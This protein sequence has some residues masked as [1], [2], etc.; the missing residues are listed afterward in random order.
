MTLAAGSVVAGRYTLEQTL[1]RGATATVWLARDSTTGDDVAVKVLHAE[2]AGSSVRV[3]FEREARR[4]AGLLHPHILPALDAGEVEDTLYFTQPLMPDGTL[5]QRLTRERQLS[6]EE[7]LRIGR[8]IAEALAYAHERTFVHRDVKPEN[9]LFGDGEV[10]LADFGIARSI[11]RSLGESSTSRLVV[12]GT[13]AYM[14]PEQASGVA[15]CD[16]RSDIFSLG[17]VL[18]ECLAGVP[19][20]VGASPDAIIA[21]VITTEPR[22]L[23][24][25]RDAVPDALA[26]IIVRCMAKR[27]ADRFRDARSLAEALAKPDRRQPPRPLVPSPLVST[28]VVPP[29]AHWGRIASGAGLIFGGVAFTAWLARSPSPPTPLLVAP[30]TARLV[31]F[32]LERPDGSRDDARFDDDLL[33]DG[34]RRGVGGPTLE[35]QVQVADALSRTPDSVVDRPAVVARALGAG[36]YVRGLLRPRGEEMLASI[37][38]YDVDSAKALVEKEV[39]VP[40]L[41]ALAAEAYART[42]AELLVRGRPG[43]VSGTPLRAGYSVPAMQAFVAGRQALDDWDLTRAESEFERA[44]GFD[45]TDVQAMLLLAQVRAWLGRPSSSWRE[46]AARA[47]ASATVLPDRERLLARGLSA[48]AEDRYADACDAYRT[49]RD[50]NPQDFAA[51]YGLGQCLSMDEVVV[52]DRAASPSGWRFR[53]SRQGAQLAYFTAFRLLPTVHRGFRRDGFDTNWSMFFLLPTNIRQ[54]ISADSQ[55]RFLARPTL[56]GDTLAMIPYLQEVVFRG[57]NAAVPAGFAK[58]IAQQRREFRATAMGWSSAFP[59]SS[60]AKEAVSLALELLEDPAALDTIRVARALATDRTRRWDLAAAEVSLLVRF[61]LPDDLPALR[62]AGAL[63]DS[64]LRTVPSGPAIS[65]ESLELL[66]ILRGRCDDAMRFAARRTV[67]S[68]E[69]EPPSAAMAESRALLDRVAMRCDAVGDTRVIG[70]FVGR[71]DRD[72]LY[73]DAPDRAY[74]DQVMLYRQV[75]MAS[76][77]DSAL[78][79]RLALTVPLPLM[80]AA[81]AVARHDPSAARAALGEFDLAATDAIPMTPDFALIAARLWS[82]AG[83]PARA[84]R[85]LDETLRQVRGIDPNV[86][87][88]PGRIAA[89]LRVMEWR[90]RLA[91]AA[92]DRSTARRWQDAIV[93]LQSP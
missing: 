67:P 87:R 23:R 18:Y 59:R 30:D 49:L 19:A 43:I 5:R 28:A 4:T 81:R 48:L 33:R 8:G 78:V 16:G 92:G 40:R 70:Q 36:R 44:H 11:E 54:G 12:R 88:D 63:A 68:S 2:L 60:E 7:T 64:L 82:D 20:F 91:A 56:L 39:V 22:E 34:F 93:A 66:S 52:P 55:S 24:I 79:E 25:Y 90:G 35:D 21:Q 74:L 1:G 3:Q 89:L 38:L 9:I 53:S 15:D 73:R 57:G 42:A 61:G 71:L 26:E 50:R 58:A 75:L 31:V 13:P 76:Q 6:V 32:P 45:P 62:R 77:R 27:A 41:I 85:I 14:S 17:S 29:R 69:G 80:R 37:A 72:P 46:L 10:Y 51:H 84:E 47:V 83:V 86:L 65:Y